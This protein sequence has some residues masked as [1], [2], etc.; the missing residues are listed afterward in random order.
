MRELWGYEKKSWERNKENSKSVVINL[1]SKQNLKC[2]ILF[3]LHEF[4][5]KLPTQ[6]NK[7]TY[8]TTGHWMF[9]NLRSNFVHNSTS[10]DL[11]SLLSFREP[12]NVLRPSLKIWCDTAGY[13]NNRKCLENQLE[14]NLYLASVLHLMQEK[15]YISP[16]YPVI[17]K[18][19]GISAK[20]KLKNLREPQTI[21]AVV[22]KQY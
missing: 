7:T 8:M 14:R 19:E 12:G 5:K 2:M 15:W 11:E 3:E 4:G 22:R 1:S 9:K 10:W 21:C 13:V 6:R 16:D 18:F 20:E 17:T